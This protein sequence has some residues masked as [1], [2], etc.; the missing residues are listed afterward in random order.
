[1]SLKVV[2]RCPWNY[3]LHRLAVRIT[4]PLTSWSLYQG[5]LQTAYEVTIYRCYLYMYGICDTITHNHDNSSRKRVN[6]NSDPLYSAPS[7]LGLM[8]TYTNRKK[9]I[10]STV[11]ANFRKIHSRVIYLPRTTHVQK[12]KINLLKTQL[13]G[14]IQPCPPDPI[15]RVLLHA[16]QWKWQLLLLLLVPGEKKTSLNLH[17]F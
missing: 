5:N 11:K 15:K 6:K 4:D 2:W 8:S 16:L 7:D 1:M 12:R 14:T 10:P 9:H 3:P 13:K 17:I